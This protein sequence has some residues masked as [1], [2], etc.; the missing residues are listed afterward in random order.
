MLT[1]NQ[2]I[3]RH[4]DAQRVF[5]QHI[6]SEENLQNIHLDQAQHDGDRNREEI[7]CF[8]AGDLRQTRALGRATCFLGSVADFGDNKRPGSM[9]QERPEFCRGQ[10]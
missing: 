8:R 7:I 10:L 3:I 2:Y 5:L 1:E 4:G 6:A 9:N